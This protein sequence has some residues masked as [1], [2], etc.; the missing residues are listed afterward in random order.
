MSTQYVD[1]LKGAEKLQS[2]TLSSYE[3]L[4]SITVN[5]QLTGK[6]SLAYGPFINLYYPFVWYRVLYRHSV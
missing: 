3:V 1:K 6:P 4:C 5:K 2:I